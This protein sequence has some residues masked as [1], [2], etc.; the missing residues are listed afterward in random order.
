MLCEKSY[1][2]GKLSPKLSDNDPAT[3][4]D[5]RSY[6]VTVSSRIVRDFR[7]WSSR[8]FDE[9]CITVRDSDIGDSLCSVRYSDEGLNLSFGPCLPFSAISVGL[10]T[11]N[12]RDLSKLVAKTNVEAEFLKRNGYEYEFIQYMFPDQEYEK[13]PVESLLM[14]LT[15]LGTIYK[16]LNLERIIDISEC[17]KYFLIHSSGLPGY[18]FATNLAG[19]DYFVPC[20]SNNERRPVQILEVGGAGNMRNCSPQIYLCTNSKRSSRYFKFDLNVQ[21][22]FSGVEYFEGTT[23]TA[24]ANEI[25]YVTCMEKGKLGGVELSIEESYLVVP[26][27]SYLF[28][29]E[30][31]L[32]DWGLIDIFGFQAILNF[33]QFIS[34]YGGESQGELIYYDYNGKLLVEFNFPRLFPRCP[35][36]LT[37]KP[38]EALREIIENELLTEVLPVLTQFANDF[39]RSG[40][41]RGEILL[42]ELSQIDSQVLLMTDTQFCMIESSNLQI[43][44]L[45]KRCQFSHQDVRRMGFSKFDLVA[46]FVYEGPDFVVQLKEKFRVYVGYSLLR[47]LLVMLLLSNFVTYLLSDPN[48]L[49]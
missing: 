39:G 13:P 7:A 4:N 25:L 41:L 21:T 31:E 46:K 26:G 35:I 28:G 43:Y 33:C 23:R 48:I 6:S 11:L 14:K 3:Q 49:G 40:E 36:E 34:M 22:D 45:P 32:T 37:Y 42:E 24:N 44:D 12:Y 9:L 18:Y 19:R 16:G 29:R 15:S 47:N 20:M 10:A 5:W 27:N 2:V 38:E 30:N 17:S 8:G 1:L